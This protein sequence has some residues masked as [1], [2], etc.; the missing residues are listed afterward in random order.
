MEEITWVPAEDIRQIARLYATSKPACIIQGECALDRQINCMQNSRALSI[1]Q[2]ITGN[3]DVPGGWVTGSFYPFTDLRVPLK[4]TAIGAEQYPLFFQR[5]VYG[6][7]VEWAPYGSESAFAETLIT[8]KPYPLKGLMV[9]AG[10][11]LVSIPDS[12]KIKRGIDKLEFVVT[13]EMWMTETAAV[14]DIVLPAASFMEQTGM[15]SWPVGSVHGIPKVSFR[16]RVIEP[17]GECWPDWK[18]WSELGRRMG[19]GEYFPWK[20]DEEV[21]E[22]MLLPCGVPF[23]EIKDNPLGV[24]FPKEYGQYKKIGFGTVS[25]KIELYSQVFEKA[26]HD[27][28]PTH[29]EPSQSPVSTPELAKE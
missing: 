19:Y 11:P 23:Q 14:S 1:L 4:K 16:P 13:M 15:G 17:L 25:G 27:P 3:I 26:G 10:N 20:T 9:C 5:G 7:E 18:I 2:A 6:D 12:E 8:E 28:M 29:K 24:Y 21:T 22:H